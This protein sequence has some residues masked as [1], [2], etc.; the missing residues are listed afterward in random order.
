ML[1]SALVSLCRL[2]LR[3]FFRR[4]EIVGEHHLPRSGS[5]ILTANH[6]NGLLDPL[7]VLCLVP[8]RISF[9]AKEPLFRTP[10]VGTFVRAFESLP[11]YR[12]Q[13]GADPTQNRLMIQHAIELLGR[14]NVLGLFPEGTSH[15]DPQLRALRTGAA[16]IALSARSAHATGDAESTPSGLDAGR[17]VSIVPVFLY[18]EQKS[19]FRSRAVLAYGPAIDVPVVPLDDAHEPPRERAR[20]LTEQLR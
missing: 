15:S 14:G 4:I 7:L 11:V 20:E 9:L 6:P 16:R 5:V 10:I 19:V 1:R 8:R 2:L 12:A 3:I 13:D 17:R 18:Y